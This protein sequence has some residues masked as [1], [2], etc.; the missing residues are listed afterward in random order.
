MDRSKQF[1]VAVEGLPFVFLS[2][3]IASLMLF[4][5]F[6]LFSLA[7]LA[8]ATLTA[9]F[10]RNPKRTIV[11]V[12][13]SVLSPADGKIIQIES[14]FEPR[15]VKKPM[16]KISIYMNLLNVH[17]NRSPITAT[18]K[19]QVHR[20]GKFR[21]ASHDKASLDNEQNAILLET[22]DNQL[23]V[24]VQIAGWIARRIVCY[25]K[26]G[27]QLISGEI[28]GLIKFGSRVDIYLP[29]DFK[30][31]VKIGENVAGGKTVIG[32]FNETS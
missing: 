28:L 29:P 27:D 32:V 3:G 26:N 7:F 23:I 11:P 5:K 6:S 22:I 2:L 9:L 25:P 13:N 1:P 18:V 8:V 17:M 10:F 4:L 20:T 19:D 15:F 16:Q 21:L 24:V 31:R 14:V 12:L 30:F